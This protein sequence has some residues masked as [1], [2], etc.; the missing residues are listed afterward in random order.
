MEN[1]VNDIF[2]ANPNYE[3]AVEI[4]RTKTPLSL[5]SARNLYESIKIG[6]DPE[7]ELKTRNDLEQAIENLKR[8]LF[9]EGGE[10]TPERVSKAYDLHE[11]LA[12]YGLALK[13][14]TDKGMKNGQN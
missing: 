7:I 5:S 8:E 1:D 13:D 3:W 11:R 4:A 12:V 14:T 2:R 10:P 6:L 9:K